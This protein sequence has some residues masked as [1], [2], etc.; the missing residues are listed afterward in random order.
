MTRLSLLVA[1]SVI[2][3]AA[4]PVLAAAFD[5]K[6]IVISFDG[7]GELGL[8]PKL[9]VERHG[10]S[11]L[12]KGIDGR[13]LRLSAGEFIVLNGE[14]LLAAGEGT[15]MFWVRPLWSSSDNGSHTFL[16]FTWRDG[17][18][19]Y[20]A[21]S[22]GWWEPKG[23]DLTYFIFNNRDQANLGKH[24]RF[25]NGQWTHIACVWK[26]G[27][28]GR[29]FVNGLAAAASTARFP[30]HGY[31]LPAR[32]YLGND[33]GVPESFRKGRWS[34]ADFD[35]LVFAKRALT[36][37]E[38]YSAYARNSTKPVSST[39]SKCGEL[40]ETRVIFDEGT[41][42]A[43]ADG[44]RRT[45][46]RVAAAGFNVYMPSV[47]HGRGTRFP[48]RMAPTEPGRPVSGADPLA[49]LIALAHEKGI[50]VHPS[51]TIS[52]RERE[53][54]PQFADPGT[55][56][57]AFDIHRQEFRR[58]IAGLIEDTVRRYPL[59]GV[60]LD[61][62]RSKGTC[63]CSLCTDE[64]RRRFERDLV[65][66]AARV[67]RDGVAAEHLLKWQAEAVEEVV[68]EIAQRVRRV[69]P[70]IIIS[71]DGHPQPY[72]N[73][74]G[75]NEIDWVAKGLVDLAFNMEYGR[76]PD[77][78]NHYHMLSR[79]ADPRTLVMMIGNYDEVGGKVVPRDEEIV[80]RL[81]DYVR[82]RW[83]NGVALYL[84]SMVTD[85][86]VEKLDKGPFGERAIPLWRKTGE[87]KP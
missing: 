29:I 50:E 19:G 45:I 46:S 1:A 5:A 21:I 51:F 17:R 37:D 83:E 39:R 30:E 35:E 33:R 28:E 75:R 81:T 25:E 40:R 13:A 38:I 11:L 72:P 63:T 49:R 42:W 6:E 78:E 69:R 62:V 48:S 47:W 12:T 55:P 8:S 71:V 36:D 80:L 9:L 74:Q 14:R 4:D 23:A 52:L 43:T 68:R 58:F 65:A 79:F 77:M 7:G 82:R 32:L 54:L 16:S 22:K 87:C 44:A 64:Y 31:A 26:G 60:N 85:E 24:I 66:D 61:Y 10:G 86:L 53:I 3:A 20:A 34:E 2:F 59:D 27:K 15:M 57:G 56:K 41:G 18:E 73:E 67:P 84:Y 76:I 70:G